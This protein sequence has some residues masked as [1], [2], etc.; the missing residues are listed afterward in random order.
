[1]GLFTEKDQESRETRVRDACEGGGGSVAELVALVE[2]MALEKRSVRQILAAVRAFGARAATSLQADGVW[3]ASGSPEWRAWDAYWR[4]TRGKGP[5]I[6]RRGGW[7]FPSR[8]PPII[9]AAE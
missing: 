7:R 5:P 2:R 9:E 1:M 8:W 3:L 4:A 6:D